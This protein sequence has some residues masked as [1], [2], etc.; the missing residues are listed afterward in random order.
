MSD[1]LVLKDSKAPTEK[2]YERRTRNMAFERY[3]DLFHIPEGVMYMI[4]HQNYSESLDWEENEYGYLILLWPGPVSPGFRARP[5][6]P[7]GRTA[8]GD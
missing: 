7:A 5:S 6:S 3:P 8:F 2:E 1:E 4:S